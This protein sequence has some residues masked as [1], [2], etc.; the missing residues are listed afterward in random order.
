M[1]FSFS[2]LALPNDD[3]DDMAVVI[4]LGIIAATEYGIHITSWTGCYTG[5]DDGEQ[6]MNW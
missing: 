5:H 3:D 2:L 4:I 1:C 6:S